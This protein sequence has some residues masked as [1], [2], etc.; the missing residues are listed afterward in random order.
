[1]ANKAQLKEKVIDKDAHQSLPRF[2][3][4]INIFHG[5]LRN[6]DI[7]DKSEEFGNV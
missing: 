7:S 1:M 4:F 5:L 2:F 3:S 6:M